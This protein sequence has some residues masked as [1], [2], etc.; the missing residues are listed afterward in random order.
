MSTFQITCTEIH[1]STYEI[2]AET[3]EQAEALFVNCDPSVKLISRDLD[4][5]DQIE[6][7]KA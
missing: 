6:V 7:T 3:A 1:N 4:A 5:T 2:E